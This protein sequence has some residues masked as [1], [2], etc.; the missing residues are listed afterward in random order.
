M[1][2]VAMK[3]SSAITL[4]LM[5]LS[6]TTKPLSGSVTLSMILSIASTPRK[7]SATEILLFAESSRVL[8]NHCVPAVN[9]GLRTSQITYLASDV[10]LSSLIGFLLYAIAEEPI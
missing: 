7:A 2:S 5:I 9:A 10:I 1:F 8:S 6:Y 4:L 3:G